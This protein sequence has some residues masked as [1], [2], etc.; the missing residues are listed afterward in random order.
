[1]EFQPINLKDLIVEVISNFKEKIEHKG[2]MVEVN[3]PPGLPEIEA[4]REKMEQ[5]LG[6]LLDNAIKFTPEGGKV[7]FTVFANEGNV[8]VEV[9]DTGIGIPPPHLS[10]IF[11]RFY[12]VDKARSRELGGTGL[13]LAIVKHIVRAHGGT[14]GVESTSGKGAK[15]FLTL[16]ITQHPST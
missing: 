10:R 14:V 15:F 7:C 9:S 8:K 5:V 2:H 3:V 13:G 12:R 16:P 1:M 11:E 6:N 4:D